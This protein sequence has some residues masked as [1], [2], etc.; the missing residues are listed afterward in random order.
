[1]PDET[2]AVLNSS[3]HRLTQT[4]VGWNHDRFVHNVDLA[5]G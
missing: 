5:L 4:Q 2:I 1:M 3:S